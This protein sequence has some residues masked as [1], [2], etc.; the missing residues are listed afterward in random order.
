[1]TLSIKKKIYDFANN[2]QKF[3]RS[4]TGYGNLK[5][6]FS[7]KK[8]INKLKIIE[9]PSGYKAYDWTVPD[10]WNYKEAYILDKNKNKILDVKKNFLHLVNYSAPIKKKMSLSELKKHIHTLPQRPN[11]IPYVT[12]YYK[13]NWGFCM[14]HNQARKLKKGNYTVHIDSE[15]KK[16]KMIFGEYFIKGKSKKE[17]FLSS[18]ICHPF[19][20][21]NEISGPSILTFL[22]NYF[23][24]KDNY[25][26]IRAVFL[27][28][29]IGSIVYLSKNLKNLKKN[30]IGGFNLS[31]L[32]DERCYS[33]L[34]SRHGNTLSDRISKNVLHQIDKNF[35][36]YTW[37]ER[38][39]DERQ[40]CSPGV[41]LPIASVSR[42]KFGEYPEYHTS[43]DDF[44][45]LVTA[46][47]LYQSYEV[48]IK[49]IEA[50][51]NNYFPRSRILC[52]PK[53][54]KYNLYNPLR[55][56]FA[57]KKNFKSTITDPIINILT[58]ADGKTS[59]LDI[60]EKLDLPI[61]K[62]YDICQ[63]LYKKKLIFLD[64]KD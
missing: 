63:L 5:T 9:V 55:K 62:L 17:I 2:L 21:N 32:G 39:S 31:C 51:Q 41:D 8:I 36:E 38:G 57:S 60:S 40:Y 11:A 44:K 12:S 10:E 1:M 4:L 27:P 6:L 48:Y 50:I 58:Y 53:L 49:L 35:K 46:K 14:T 7:I 29:T 54:S 59:L 37:L 23:K 43:D 19:M 52:E 61:W 30:V 16:G 28:E 18:Y 64:R 26:S 22:L 24:E 45:K 42:S 34:P 20:A 47:G 13:K 56:I 3:P 33:Y 25:Y 15:F